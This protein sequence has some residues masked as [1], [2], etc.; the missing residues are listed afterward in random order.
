MKVLV[1]GSEGYIGKHLCAILKNLDI[2]L[3]KLDLNIPDGVNHYQCDIRN[4]EDLKGAYNFVFDAVI[5]LAAL[6]RVGESVNY[7]T[8]YYDTNIN[9]TINVIKNICCSNFI[10]AST[11]AAS[12]PLSPYGFSKRVAEDIVAEKCKKFTSFRFYNVTGTNGF[13]ATNPDGLFYN[14][15]KAVET[16]K[17]Y[18]HGDDY[19]TKDGTCVRE[20]IHVIDVCR[21]LIKAIYKPSNKIENLAYNDPRTVKEIIDVFKN[22]NEVDF[23][24]ITLP[25]RD[26]DIEAMYLPNPSD[27]MV[28]NYTYEEMMRMNHGKVSVF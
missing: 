27:Y 10:F 8:M 20:Y 4:G 28:R 17:F 18:L 24:V 19:N 9:G 2:E 6:V 11:G 12:N 23:D 26:G 3:Y 16:K 21:A 22:V 15:T 5:H 13:P 7:P 14:L 25:R 1:T